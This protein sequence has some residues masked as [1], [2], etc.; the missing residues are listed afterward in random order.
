[1]HQLRVEYAFHLFSSFRTSDELPVRASY[2]SCQYSAYRAAPP[3]CYSCLAVPDKAASQRLQMFSCTAVPSFP[4]PDERSSCRWMIDLPLVETCVEFC[5]RCVCPVVILLIALEE[6]LSNT[7]VGV[8]INHSINRLID[9]HDVHLQYAFVFFVP[10]N[11][12]TCNQI[13]DA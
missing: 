13:V 7:A 11:V 2:Q 6:E 8:L 10:Y 4:T 5:D 9:F 12:P 1:M 3:T